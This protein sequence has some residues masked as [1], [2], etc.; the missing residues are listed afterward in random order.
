MMTTMTWLWTSYNKMITNRSKYFSM[1][2]QSTKMLPLR[3]DLDEL[4]KP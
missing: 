2:T 4:W 3:K 1:M